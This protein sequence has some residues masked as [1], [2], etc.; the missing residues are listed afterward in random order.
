VRLHKG[1]PDKFLELV[2]RIMGSGAN[3]VQ[4]FNDET[5]IQG[6]TNND[7]PLEDAR[8]YLISGCVQQ[9]P[10]ATYGSVC[11]AHLVLPR[12]L[13]LFLKKNQK[14]QS[15]EEFYKSYTGYLS[16]VIKQATITLSKVD[17]THQELLPNTFISALVEGAMQNGRDVKSG[18]AKHNLTGISLLGLGTLADSLAAVRTAV[19][20][21]QVYTLEQLKKLLRGNFAGRESDRLYLINKIPKYGNDDD[22][23]DL[24]ARDLANFCATEVKRY[25]TFRGGKF[26][27][28]VHSENGQVVFGYVTGATPDGRKLLEPYSIGA[29]SA[30]GR[31]KQGYTATLKSVSKLDSSQVISG[32]SVNLRFSPSLFDSDNKIQRFKDMIQAYFFDY[33][34][35]NLQT[36][37]V[38]IKTL[39]QAQQHPEDF[40]DLLVRISGY[41]ARFVELT[42]QTQDEIISRTEYSA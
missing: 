23:V 28:G 3:T 33:G 42:R 37:V 1:T 34:G 4:I 36:T 25:T 32:I 40:Q 6:F 24:I 18:G 2:A 31:E 16:Y 17:K 7:I 26:S 12:I 10:A 8:D 5:V 13:E 29:G 21:R 30:R 39:Q 27:I 15:Y 9:I 41:S 35:Q 22:S 38:D 14:Y 11:A 20:E 19:F